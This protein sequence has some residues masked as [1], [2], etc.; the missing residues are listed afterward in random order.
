MAT[1]TLT[2]ISSHR[3]WFDWRLGQLRRYRDLISLLVWRDFHAVAGADRCV[4]FGRA[5]SAVYG[6][7]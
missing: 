1:Q 2:I 6:E 4:D 5:S 3:G 7:A